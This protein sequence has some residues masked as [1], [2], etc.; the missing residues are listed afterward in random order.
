MIIYYFIFIY[1]FDSEDKKA[2]HNWNII[3]RE[4]RESTD[5]LMVS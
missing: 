1:L 2:H 4:K 3:Q 5:E